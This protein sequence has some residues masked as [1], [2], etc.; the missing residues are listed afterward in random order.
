MNMH[1]IY[2]IYIYIIYIHM[3]WVWKG[4]LYFCPYR[5]VGWSNSV[6]GPKARP[7][8]KVRVWISVKDLI[9]DCSAM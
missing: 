5:P 8:P 1:N 7:G 3:S 9:E 2:N 6:P 4:V